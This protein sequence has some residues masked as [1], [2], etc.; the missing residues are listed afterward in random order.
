MPP[1]NPDLIRALRIAVFAAL[2]VPAAI[3]AHDS[4]SGAMASPFRTIV[5]E[6]GVWSVRLLVLGLLI[7]P[8]RDVTGWT[9]PLALRRMIGLFAAFYAAVHILAW[10]RQYG[11]DWPFLFGEVVRPWLLIGAL[12]ALA[13]VPMVLTSASVMHRLLGSAMW[14]RVHKLVY[15]V[16]ILA[17]VHYAMARGLTRPE[18][19][20]AALLVLFALLW[21]VAPPAFVRRAKAL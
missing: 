13:M 21:R 20:I 6:T 9:W 2:S 14:G 3:L 7:A 16:A 10:T 17:I 1:M 12:G 15:A 8:L 4:S 18:M 19:P 11:F 5:Q